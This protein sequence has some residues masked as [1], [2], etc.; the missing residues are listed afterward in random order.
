MQARRTTWATRGFAFGFVLPVLYLCL[1]QL[2]EFLPGNVGGD[3]PLFGGFLFSLFVVGL[4][5][6]L[7]SGMLGALIGVV[8]AKMS[9]GEEGR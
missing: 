8:G 4:P 1:E 5:M 6:G 7:V 9:N 2:S 3:S